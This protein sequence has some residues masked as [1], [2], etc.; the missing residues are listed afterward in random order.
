[1]PKRLPSKRTIT[2]PA[3][4]ILKRLHPGRFEPNSHH[5]LLD[6][7]GHEQLTQDEGFSQRPRTMPRGFGHRIPSSP[8]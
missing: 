8:Y 5:G 1:M 2:H 4:R 3:D 6:E 7:P